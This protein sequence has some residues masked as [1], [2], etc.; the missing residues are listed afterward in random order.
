MQTFLK[1][2][3]KMRFW[4]R[5]FLYRLH[6]PHECTSD[7]WSNILPLAFLEDVLLHTVHAVCENFEH[8]PRGTLWPVGEHDVTEMGIAGRHA[9]A[10]F[11][12]LLLQSCKCRAEFLH[13][14]RHGPRG[15]V[16]GA[17]PGR[18]HLVVDAHV[19][20]VALCLLPPR[21]HHPRVLA[22]VAQHHRHFG[23]ADAN[24][25]G[26]ELHGRGRGEEDGAESRGGSWRASRLLDFWDDTLVVVFVC[27][28]KVQHGGDCF[29]GADG[30]PP[31]SSYP[32]K[33]GWN[34]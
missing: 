9:V 16:V 13:C 7:S 30:V 17:V 23:V 34:R 15:L 33:C 12:S 21:G 28:H 6:S 11:N 31:L 29:G 8:V 5:V 25:H 32:L 10:E 27:V 24:E 22:P 26:V 4:T 1:L 3:S 18:R 14:V 20:D 19:P 2:I